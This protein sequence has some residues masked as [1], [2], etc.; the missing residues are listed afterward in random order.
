MPIDGERRCLIT[1]QRQAGRPHADGTGRLTTLCRPVA[2]RLERDDGE[3]DSDGGG[4]VVVAVSG[5]DVDVLVDGL[6]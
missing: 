1:G 3:A 5:A 4:L 2:L 6:P